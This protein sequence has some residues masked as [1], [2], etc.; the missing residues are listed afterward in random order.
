MF[1]AFRDVDYFDETATRDLFLHTWSLGVEE[2]FYLAWPLGLLLWFAFARFR[3][4]TGL[5]R[6]ALPLLLLLALAFVG[7]LWL[8]NVSTTLAFYLMPARMWEFVLG[9][10]VFVRQNTNVRMGS[11][12]QGSDAGANA[13]ANVRSHHQPVS[14]HQ[15]LLWVG[16]GL[17]LTSA[18]FI[19][20]GMAH[21]ALWALAPAIGTALIIRAGGIASH[22]SFLSS[23]GMVWLGDRSYTLYL[24]HWPVLKLGTALGFA[25]HS[26]SLTAMLVLTLLLADLSYRFIERPLWKT[27]LQNILPRQVIM[28]SLLVMGLLIAVWRPVETWLT[29]PVTVQESSLSSKARNDLPIIYSMGCDGFIHTA[30]LQPCVFKDPAYN[31]A[32]ILLGDSIG[33]QWFSAVAKNFPKP[34][35]R[36]TVL[37]KSSCAILDE[38]YVYRGAGGSYKVCFDWREQ[39]L[40]FIEAQHPDVVILGSAASYDFTDEQWREGSARYFA[41]LSQVVGMV[42]VIVG[43][44]WLSFD[45]PSCIERMMGEDRKL[46]TQ[47][48]RETLENATQT[49]VANN[50]REAARRYSN[51]V[52]LDPSMLVCPNNECVAMTND[53]Q[54]VFRDTQHLTDSFVRSIA[55]KLEQMFLPKP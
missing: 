7:S 25:T 13:L 51:V 18:V 26:A 20:E 19:N 50:L 41:R 17:L 38:E 12:L 43:T 14:P 52:V 44:P 42:Y 46:P 55:P 37:T 48:C 36:L 40:R 2:Q 21:P 22:P 5:T 47:V 9:A 29:P 16:M 27:H 45:G 54:M 3:R 33:A 15:L 10:L 32:V 23:S 35:W 11:H 4:S 8:S 28:V 1:F 53:G 30:E 39:A 24:W 31:K 49:N 6:I 34:E